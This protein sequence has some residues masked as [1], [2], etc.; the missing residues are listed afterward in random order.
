MYIGIWTASTTR[1]K[2]ISGKKQ[3]LLKAHFPVDVFYNEATYDIQYGNV[4]RPT[5][6]NTS[7]DV[8]RFEVCAH[9][10]ADVSEPGYGVSLLNDCKYGHSIDE[11]GMALTLL[12]SSTH[13]NPEADQEKHVFTYSLM[14]HVGD[15]REG[16]TV[17]MAYQLNIPVST[18]P[19]A[20]PGAPASW[21]GWTRTGSS[22]RRSSASWTAKGSS[23]GFTNATAGR[24]RARLKLGFE[25]KDAAECDLMERIT[26]PAE[27][28]GQEVAMELK[29]YEIKTFLFNW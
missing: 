18:M 26:G 6:K 4:K 15:W 2:W 19:A 9:K 7:W 14:P 5:H 17:P 21:P 16:G 11:D 27:I 23:S 1:P 25:V 24:T 3:Y 10:W 20:R 22:S 12:K 28:S 29:P 8:A 13:P